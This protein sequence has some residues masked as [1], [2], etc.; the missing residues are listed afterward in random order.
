MLYWRKYVSVSVCY[1]CLLLFCLYMV[2][3]LLT[4]P[5]APLPTLD[6]PDYDI[7]FSQASLTYIRRPNGQAM[8]LNIHLCVLV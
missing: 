2:T 7:V 5:A 1:C 6:P 4:R 3:D 8:I